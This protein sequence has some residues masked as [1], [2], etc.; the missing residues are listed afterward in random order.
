MKA[1]EPAWSVHYYAVPQFE[2]TGGRLLANAIADR[3]SEHIDGLLPHVQGMRLPVLRETRMPAVLITVGEI[4]LAIDHA[5]SVIEAV[6]QALAD[7]AQPFTPSSGAV[8]E[9]APP[10]AHV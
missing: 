3:L 7:W 5:P 10:N 8:D 1:L 4:Q 6:V 2:S 9:S